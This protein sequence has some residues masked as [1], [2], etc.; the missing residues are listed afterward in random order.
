MVGL[1]PTVR[2][3]LH[4]KPETHECA[5]RG[6]LENAST[7]ASAAR[8]K[9]VQIES[10]GALTTETYLLGQGLVVLKAIGAIA[11]LK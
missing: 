2:L 7:L 3:A 8:I 1:M 9:V 4:V 10:P 11:S 5:S 6:L